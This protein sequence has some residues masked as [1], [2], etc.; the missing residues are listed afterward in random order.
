MH[1]I[2]Q[3]SG[4]LL[5]ALLLG[6][7]V[8]CP[9]D[10][11]PD[12]ILVDI[13]NAPVVSNGLVADAPTEFNA[14]LNAK[15]ADDPAFALDPARFGHQIPAGG[16]ME[17]QLTGAF[18][19]NPVLEVDPSGFLTNGHVILTTGPQNPIHGNAGDSVQLGN[20]TATLSPNVS[21]GGHIITITPDGGNGKNG[22]EG[23]RAKKIGVKIAHVRPRAGIA[24]F[25][26]GP[27][28]SVGTVAVRI[29]DADGTLREAGVADVMFRSKAD[30]GPQVAITNIGV[31]TGGAGAPQPTMEV[32]ENTN[33]QRV[34]P[35]SVLQNTARL[36]GTTTFSESAPYAPRFILFQAA[37]AGEP[38]NVRIV[39]N[40]SVDPA[41]PYLAT[42]SDGSAQIGT[43]SIN[44]PSEASRGS[45][46]ADPAT[47]S[48]IL[49]VPVQVGAEKGVYRVTVRLLGGNESVNTI[50]VK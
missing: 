15:G 13:I 39:A 18:I 19:I 49:S 28:G 23:E 9:A 38:N 22:L 10:D 1:K 20:W 40:Y 2:I 36:P 48:N 11:K 5:G 7:T 43:V 17:I 44:G 42:L 31:S 41:R 46:L 25:S 29:Y 3:Q 8:V 16:R 14:I 34:A 30:V 24:P 6:V 37:A 12:N 33:F 50:I 21:S 4:W 32:N 45:L 47:G 27:A 35:N 26:N